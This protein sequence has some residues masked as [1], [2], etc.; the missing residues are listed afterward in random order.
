MSVWFQLLLL[1]FSDGPSARTVQKSDDNSCMMRTF[2]CLVGV[3]VERKAGA[4]SVLYQLRRCKV[5]FREF[6]L[7]VT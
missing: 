3:E 4:E 7:G 5:F 6:F 1:F 2:Q